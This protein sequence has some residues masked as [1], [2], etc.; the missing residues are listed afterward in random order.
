MYP[1]ILKP[2]I[3]DYIWGGNRLKTEYNKQSDGSILA[4]SWELSCHKEG[5]SVINNGVL[6]GTPLHNYISSDKVKILGEMSKK[7]EDLPILVKLIDAKDN[8][9]IQVHPDNNYALKN[10]GQYGKTEMW[11]ILDCEPNSFIY[12]GLNR[13]LKPGEFTE[14]IKN[15]LLLETLNVVKVKKGDVFF[16]EPGTV[17]AIC[18]GIL[19]AEIQQN[20]NITYRIYDYNRLG[21][22]GRPRELHI[23]KALDVTN[24]K[25]L[26]LNP[27]ES[28]AEENINYKK[29]LLSKCDYF[30]VYNIRINGEISLLADGESFHCILC[31][32]GSPELYHGKHLIRMLKGQTIFIPANM[33]SYK[34]VGNCELLFISL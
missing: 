12:Y 27:P 28:I 11:Y 2:T 15:N 17:H 33:G 24:M 19:L 9:S 10:E 25:K 21:N 5:M 4:E 14:R 1:M 26:N 16:I 34:I 30:T 6:S 20:S 7:F 18:G 3:K 8:L 13:N 23:S 29:R 32:E 22:D 31:L